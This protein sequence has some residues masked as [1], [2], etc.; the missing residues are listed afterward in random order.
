MEIEIV[1]QKTEVLAAEGIPFCEIA[2]ALPSPVLEGRGAERIA[3]FYGAIAEGTRALGRE[4][5]LPQAREHYEKSVDPRRRF[6][7]RP[8]RLMHTAVIEGE[9]DGLTVTRTLT[10]VHRGRT[11]LW[12]EVR[13]HITAEGRILP[14]RQKAHEKQKPS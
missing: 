3:R 4:V 5:L 2:L 8:Y 9:G 13:E 10:L 14:K 6:T 7:H 1:R 12:E 11:L